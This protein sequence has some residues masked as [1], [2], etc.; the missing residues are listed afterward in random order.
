MQKKSNS[1]CFS[2]LFTSRGHFIHGVAV[3]Q[4]VERV[5]QWSVG[6][7]FESRLLLGICHVSLGKTL[8]PTLPPMTE[9]YEWYVWYEWYECPPSLV[10]EWNVGKCER[11][12]RFVTAAAP[13][14]NVPMYVNEWNIVSALSLGKARYKCNSLLLL[15]DVTQHQW[16]H[17]I[18]NMKCLK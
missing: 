15:F 16:P 1:I 2:H 17:V 14:P 12:R 9:W 3:A 18:Q 13:P 7:R 10:Y 11:W 5:G 8:N 4:L 6:W